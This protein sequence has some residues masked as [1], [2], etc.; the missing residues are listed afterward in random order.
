[1]Q[2]MYARHTFAGTCGTLTHLPGGSVSSGSLFEVAFLLGRPISPLLLV[3][4]VILT[5]ANSIDICFMSCEYDHI[6][7]TTGLFS[8]SVFL[9]ASII[10][11]GWAESPP[12]GIKTAGAGHN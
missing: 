5:A 9:M 4:L 3:A 2:S 1:M 12:S 6:I 7:Q 11:S 8:V 10:D